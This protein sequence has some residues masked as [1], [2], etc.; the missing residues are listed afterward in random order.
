MILSRHMQAL[1]LSALIASAGIVAPFLWVLAPVGL[2]LFFRTLRTR[3]VTIAR[4]ML[5]GLIFGTTTAGAAVGWFWET[6]PLDFLGI[7]KPTVQRVSV[8]MT[9]LYVSLSLG[10]AIAL[11]SPAIRACGGIYG[12]SV[13]CALLWCVAERGRMWGF[14]LTTWAPGAL[15]GAHFSVASVGYPLTESEVLRAF[16]FPWG[17]DGLNFL[18]AFCAAAC[19]QLSLW[20]D[21]GSNIKLLCGELV[22]VGLILAM[23]RAIIRPSA[24]G[25]RVAELRFAI[26]ANSFMDVR[27]V[28]SHSFIQGQIAEAARMDPPI[29]VLVFPEEFSLTSVFWS[30]EE[31]RDFMRAHLGE[32]D[33]L[34]MHTRNDAFP[35]NETNNSPEPKK[36]VYESTS[37]GELGRHIKR[38]LM[39]LG[40]YAPIF[41]RTFFALVDDPELQVY[42]DGVHELPL[43]VQGADVT[44]VTW[45]GV[46]IGGLLCSELLSPSLYRSLVVRGRARI[47]VNLANQFWFHGSRS[48]HDKT[49]QIARV[50]ATQNHAPFILANNMA[51]S[52]VLGPRGE[53]LK[54]SAW[55][56]ARPLY[57]SVRVGIESPAM[58]DSQSD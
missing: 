31:A 18:A 29:D 5:C 34:I 48:L 38:H 56:E 44:P 33:I 49:L 53:L 7:L 1:V 57:V 58:G 28:S 22:V 35:A 45:K 55:G 11:V 32:R 40:E 9:W 15:V 36:L 20:R 17:I 24:G 52:F 41:T 21:K 26:L 10:I 42:V 43:S 3:D 46:R 14:S 54:E 4:V 8:G 37:M 27:D 6:L 30:A 23:S 51:P 25:D 50:H 12:G 19:V 13:I 16:A 47:L 39:P 2:A